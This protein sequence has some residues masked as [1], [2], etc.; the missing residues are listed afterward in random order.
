M[1]VCRVLHILKLLP[2]VF[3]I[4]TFLYY[5]QPMHNIIY[6]QQYRQYC[7]MFQHE[8]AIFRD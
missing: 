7:Q 1:L 2:W 5:N 3:Q 6:I 4:D 8:Y